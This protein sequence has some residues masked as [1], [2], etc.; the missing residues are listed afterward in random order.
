M[1]E[2]K[3]T[4]IKRTFNISNASQGRSILVEFIKDTN[5]KWFWV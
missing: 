3:M 2:K 4:V 5:D 1:G